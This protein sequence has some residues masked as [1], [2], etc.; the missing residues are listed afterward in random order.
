MKK[1]EIFKILSDNT[2]LC[3]LELLFSEKRDLCVNEISK[4][5]G[6]SH[7]AVS[8]QLAKLEDKGLVECFRHGKMMC[9]RIKEGKFSNMIKNIIKIAEN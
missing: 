3:I 6:I 5:V 7:S 9:Y 4:T 2:R 8:H 1:S